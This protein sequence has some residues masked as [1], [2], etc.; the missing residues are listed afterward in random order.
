MRNSFAV[1]LA[2]GVVFSLSSSA[3]MPVPQARR[4]IVVVCDGLTFPMLERM[5]E[6]VPTLLRRSAIG[7]LSGTSASLQG[8]QGV[9]VTLGSGKR[10]DANERASL[11][12]WLQI[13]RAHV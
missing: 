3:M 1:W 5:G 12:A 4:L 2:V 8:C 11:A 13:G 9:Y 7:L 6:P 10:Q